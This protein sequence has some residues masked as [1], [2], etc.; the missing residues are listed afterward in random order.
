MYIDV[1]WGLFAP[2]Q[3]PKSFHIYKISNVSK[4]IYFVMYDTFYVSNPIIL[5]PIRYLNALNLH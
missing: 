3:E 5:Y 2:T 1:A 4:K